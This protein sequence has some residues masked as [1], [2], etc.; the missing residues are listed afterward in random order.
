M[1]NEPTD[2]KE[3]AELNKKIKKENREAKQPI[4]MMAAIE[5]LTGLGIETTNHGDHITFNYQGETV[6]YWPFTGWASGKSI[7]DGR[8]LIKLLKQLQ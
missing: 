1:D 3:W 7:K 4:M 6:T 2:A 8:G 5:A